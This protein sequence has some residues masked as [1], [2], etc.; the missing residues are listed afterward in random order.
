MRSPGIAD[1]EACLFHSK[2]RH[3]SGPSDFCFIHG[4]SQRQNV[5]NWFRHLRKKS[6]EAH[7]FPFRAI[8]WRAVKLVS[9][10]PNEPTHSVKT[11]F[12]RGIWLSPV[13]ARQLS[14]VFYQCYLSAAEREATNFAK[15]YQQG[16]P[17]CL[18]EMP[19][20]E[21][22]TIKEILV[23][24]CWRISPSW[25]SLTEDFVPTICS[26]ELWDQTDWPKL[27]Y[28]DLKSEDAVTFNPNLQFPVLTHG[29]LCWH[30]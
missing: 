13:K 20:K 24:K 12:Y 5:A 28:I 26:S 4:S 30:I 15:D 6:R 19:N 7:Q 27:R 1:S 14:V 22:S 25:N 8:S 18:L 10:N 21:S 16:L 23:R 2:R 17:I 29:L 9:W 3:S 11:T